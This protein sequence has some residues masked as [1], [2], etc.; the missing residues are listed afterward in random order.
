MSR[1]G[2]ILIVLVLL[3][4]AVSLHAYYR[5]D[6]V[7][8]VPQFTS[9]QDH[10]LYGSVGTEGERGVPY[11]IWLVL[12]RIFPEYLPA[13]GGYASIGIMAHDGHEMP[14]GFSKVEIGVPRVGV[15][16]ALCH[17]ATVRAAAADAPTVYPGAPAHQ[18]GA[19]EYV[20]FLVAA[21]SDPRFTAD[22][23]LNEIARNV[24]LSLPDR[25]L[26][27]FV[28]IPDT[29]RALLRLAD[30]DPATKREWGRGRTDLVGHAKFTIL[31][32]RADATIGTA[33]AM[34]LWHLK[35]REANGYQWDRSMASLPEVV[36]SSA[37]I[38]GASKRWMDIDTVMWDRSEA[39]QPSSLRRVLEYLSDLQAPK[40]PFAVD[41]T[42]AA[43]GAMTYAAACAQCHDGN[44]ARANSPI[45]I[46]EIGTDRGRLDAWTAGSAEAF[47]AFGEGHAWK[48]SS[49]RQPSSG[50]VAPPLDGVWLNAP[51]LHNGSVPTLSD[52]LEPPA[53]RPARFWSG[54]DVYDQARVGFI[55][56]GPDAQRL[57]TLL[58]VTQPGNG[59]GGHTYGTTLPADQK[60]ALLEYLKTR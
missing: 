54:Y 29:R 27:R 11:L 41:A 12:P 57:G 45:P 48:F 28:L 33:D 35:S 6:R 59:N 39:R 34:P 14:I 15:N 44:G 10:F 20:R 60:R 8:P 36:R 37:L 58:D 2:W 13:P 5:L 32:Q 51:Y 31:R 19:Q 24:Q 18:T 42:L 43:A 16:C 49:S 1:L 7:A 56:D 3:M 30:Q 23:I 47:N 40:Y 17:T 4:G 9:A 26:Y 22:T 55:S 53:S 38:E 25:L 50:Y 21:A 52:L 46:A